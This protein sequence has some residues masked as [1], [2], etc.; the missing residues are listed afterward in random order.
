MPDPDIPPIVL[1]E[2]YI[3]EI[4]ASMP[5]V[6]QDY[7]D[8][9]AKIGLE[10]KV[11]EDILAVPDTAM[12]VARVF[13]TAGADHA[14]RVA[15]WLLQPQVDD[16]DTASDESDSKASD[17]QLIALSQMVADNKLSS[18][19]AKEVLAEMLQDW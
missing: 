18:T 9:F 8:M 4:E 5:L 17:E 1:E 3:K 19:A 11:S 7:R 10:P 2:S 14:K 6:P 16:E 12:A 15:F 13:G